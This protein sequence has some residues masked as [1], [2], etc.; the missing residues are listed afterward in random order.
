MIMESNTDFIAPFFEK[1]IHLGNTKMELW[2]L[3]L[4]DNFSDIVAILFTKLLIA[5]VFVVFLLFFSIALSIW[6][7]VLLGKSYYGFLA[8]S[9]I[10]GLISFILWINYRSIKANTNNWIINKMLN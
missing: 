5:M 10:Y 4:L 7:G 2:K 6:A 8:V 1:A 9:S 3:K